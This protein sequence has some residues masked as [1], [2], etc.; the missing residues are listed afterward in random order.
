[1]IDRNLIAIPAH[2]LVLL[3]K[4]VPTH[5]HSNI[6][7]DTVLTSSVSNLIISL[8]I[9]IMVDSGW[10]DIHQVLNPRPRELKEG[11]GRSFT[12]ISV[13]GGESL[14][15]EQ[16]GVACL[17]NSEELRCLYCSVGDVD[18][19]WQLIHNEVAAE[20]NLVYLN[21]FVGAPDCA[22]ESGD[23]VGDLH[24]CGIFVHCHEEYWIR[25]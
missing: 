17:I 19:G 23:Q 3:S 12:Q 2:F 18:H 8:P 14:I 13:V 15:C 25:H 11:G 5:S 20:D 4:T 9:L 21:V 10:G 1:M 24:P 22:E 16:V 7:I 6:G